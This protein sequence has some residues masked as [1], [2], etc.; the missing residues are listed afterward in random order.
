MPDSTE[1]M[2]RALQGLATEDEK[3]LLGEWLDASPQNRARFEELRLVFG[4]AERACPQVRSLRRPRARDLLRESAPVVPPAAGSRVG[5]P[6]RVAFRW[7]VPLAAAAGIGALT[8]GVHLKPP[9]PPDPAPLFATG[10]FSTG[11]REAVTI[12]LGDRTIVRL[13]PSSLLQ[14]DGTGGKRNVWLEGDAFFAVAHHP[15]APFTV[16]TPSG[17]ATALGTRFDVSARQKDLRL[18]VV[19]GRVRVEAGAAQQYVEELGPKQMVQVVDTGRMFVSEVP[20]VYAV[21][22][23]MEGAL[24]FQSTPLGSVVMELE[25]RYGLPVSLV[26]S[27][28]MNRTITAWFT[29][30][31]LERVVTVICRAANLTCDVSEAGVRLGL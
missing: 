7:L 10:E 13:G 25:R 14:V 18:V 12:R 29:D 28:L 27:A 5:T 19:D 16:R 9:P 26:D 17:T 3:R 24:V 6:R 2:V 11:P 21:L 1:L 8:I 15:D 4:L 23:W 20:D 30:E 22:E 31:P